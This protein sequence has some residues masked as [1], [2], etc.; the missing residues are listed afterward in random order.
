MITPECSTV[1]FTK[2][3]D[4]NKATIIKNDIVEENNNKYLCKTTIKVVTA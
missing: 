4:V 2:I 1:R 3:G